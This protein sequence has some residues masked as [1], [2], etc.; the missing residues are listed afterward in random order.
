MLS[1]IGHLNGN[2]EKVK[3]LL[4]SLFRRKRFYLSISFVGMF[5]Y[6]YDFLELRSSDGVLR[7]Y[8]NE[9]TFNYEASVGYQHAENERIRYVE[10]GSDSLPL[11]VFV[12]G[13]PSSLSF[14]RTFLKDSTL[15]SH[16]K[17]LAFDRPGYGYSGFGKT[18]TSLAK[19]A[20]LVAPILMSKRAAHSKIILLGSSY[21]GTLAARLAMD[22]P[23]LVD[24]LVFQS[25]SLA[26]GEETTY[27]I[28]YPTSHW[29]LRWLLP[30]TFRVAN[31]EKLSHGRE[32]Q[33]MLP[34][35]PK[36]KAS[37][38]IL[39]GD[40]DGLIYPSNAYFAAQHLVNAS[41]V[42]L[43][44]IEGRG[45]NLAW[46]ERG[47]IIDAAISLARKRSALWR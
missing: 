28:T 47:L 36:I 44:I 45:H 12:H 15:L 23:E 31:A 46:T 41:F 19:Q 5:I 9:N 7:T 8:L 11:L 34:L 27:W 37:C 10:V 2:F 21:G 13:A 43:S 35:W 26:P 4:I 3:R 16:F 40:N 33:E 39:H 22:Y 1:L 18:V 38:I 14:W 32:L 30:T 24:G 25:S 17:L 20:A 42:K 29:S 6:A